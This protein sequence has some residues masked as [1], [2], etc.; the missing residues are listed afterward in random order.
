MSKKKTS[1][2]KRLNELDNATVKDLIYTDTHFHYSGI[3]EKCNDLINKEDN[4]SNPWITKNAIT[5]LLTSKNFQ[6]MDIGT[7]Y[8]DLPIRYKTMEQYRNIH[9][10]SGIG[11]WSVDRELEIDNQL[12]IFKNNIMNYPISAI[13]EIGLDYYWKF[14]TPQKQEELFIKQLD[15]ANDLKLPI[16]IHS[17]D[18][19]E[20]T[21]NIIKNREF[22]FGGIIHCF[23]GNEKLAKQAIKSNLLISFAGPITYKKNE[24]LR[25]ILKI[26]PTKSLLLETDSPYLPPEPFRGK[27]NSPY[28]IPLIYEKASEIKNISIQEISKIVSNN[29]LNLLG[30]PKRLD[31]K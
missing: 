12:K 23:S 17:R 13:G 6:G 28:L 5:D 16:I 7:Q 18:A 4:T 8:D 11:P 9:I 3:I 22:P 14:G 27:Y 26:V 19:D 15:I 29:F 30:N 10:S 31:L 21:I 2:S 24:E 25:E 1:N 20:Q